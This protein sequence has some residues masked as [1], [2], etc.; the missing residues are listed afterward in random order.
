MLGHYLNLG[1]LIVS[2]HPQNRGLL[3][4]YVNFQSPNRRTISSIFPSAKNADYSLSGGQSAAV[5]QGVNGWQNTS[6][7]S[8]TGPTYPVSTLTACGAF[9][10]P[11]AQANF[12]GFLCNRSGGNFSLTFLADGRLLLTCPAGDVVAGPVYT[13]NTWYWWGVSF[14][15]GVA[16]NV[17]MNR[18]TKAIS[19]SSI[20]SGAPTTTGAWL[21]GTDSGGAGR[22]FIG[23]LAEYKFLSVNLGLDELT[24]MGQSWLDNYSGS[25]S[26]LQRWSRASWFVSPPA[27][28][29]RLSRVSAL[30]GLGGS[31]QTLFNPSLSGV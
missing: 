21:L 17:V 25:D 30:E 19:R 11:A 27:A 24:A 20:S 7:D 8:I 22:S 2:G 15:G 4:W 14:S 5:L 13:T 10:S 12:N 6:G 23:Y 9:Y 18:A 31:G 26:P 16:N 28:T 29:G 1:N 3:G